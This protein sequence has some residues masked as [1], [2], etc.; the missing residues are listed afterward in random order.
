MLQFDTAPAHRVLAQRADALFLAPHPALRH[1]VAHYTVTLPTAALASGLDEWLTL[2]PDAAGCFV[3]SL[4]RD[5]RGV[6]WGATTKAARVHRDVGDGPERFF[7]EFLPGGAHRLTGLSMHALTDHMF[8]I[9]EVLPA[10]YA[11]MKT[12]LE[13][14]EGNL[15]KTTEGMDNILLRQL[16]KHGGNSTASALLPLLGMDGATVRALAQQAGYSERHLGRLFNASLG[17]SVKT[18]ARVLRINRALAA[19]RPGVQFT[20]LAQEAGYYD[21]AHFNHDFRAVCGVS[22]GVYLARMADFYKEDFKF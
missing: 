19:I 4:Q 5:V 14:A 12:A 16:A 6:V 8:S 20:Q 22:P 11:E 3:F 10:L 21:Q 18:C 9:G 1:C 15:A 13:C 7:V 2:L 17:V